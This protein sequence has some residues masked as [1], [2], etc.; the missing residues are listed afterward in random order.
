MTTIKID[1]SGSPKCIVRGGTRRISDIGCIGKR[2]VRITRGN[3]REK[4]IGIQSKNRKLIWGQGVSEHFIG[5]M[6]K[7]PAMPPPNEIAHPV[8]RQYLTI[9]EIDGEMGEI[10]RILE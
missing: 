3:K 2:M 7:W 5:D 10:F 1:T 4:L 8:E 9:A 6:E